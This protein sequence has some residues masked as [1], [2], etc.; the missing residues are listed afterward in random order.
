MS[1]K[2]SLF[3]EVMHLNYYS[4]VKKKIIFNFW[5]KIEISNFCK[6]IFLIL[7]KSL[8]VEKNLKQPHPLLIVYY[9]MRLYCLNYCELYIV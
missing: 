4:K 8:F 7:E 9:M 5:V 3:I 6:K 1:K 2:K